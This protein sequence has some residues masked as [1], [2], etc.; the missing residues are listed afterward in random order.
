MK[1]K[2]TQRTGECYTWEGSACPNHPIFQPQKF[3]NIVFEELKQE[4]EKVENPFKY[5]LLGDT[6]YDVGTDL[7]FEAC[8]QAILKILT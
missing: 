1:E 2:I 4:T 7:G 5:V 8:R 3:L 6:L